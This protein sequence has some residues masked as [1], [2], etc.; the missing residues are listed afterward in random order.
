MG[1]VYTHTR[2]HKHLVLLLLRFLS[3]LLLLQRELLTRL[4]SIVL[5]GARLAS[6]CPTLEH[7]W[8]K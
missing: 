7:Y 4:V 6:W 8:R 2:T 1:E 3:Y 5:E